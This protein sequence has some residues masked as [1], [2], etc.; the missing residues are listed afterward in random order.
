MQENFTSSAACNIRANK[1]KKGRD[2]RGHVV[3]IAQ[4]RSVYKI[5]VGIP[6]GRFRE[7]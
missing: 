7:V 3:R 6:G 2:A 1:F 5:L 4:I